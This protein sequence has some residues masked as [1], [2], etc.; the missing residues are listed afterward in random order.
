MKILILNYEYP[1]LGGGAGIVTKHLAEEFAKMNHAVVVVT[2]WFYGEPEYYTNNNITIVRLKSR[3]NNTY[4]S[5][6]L[7]MLSWIRYALN[8]FKNQPKSDLAFDIYARWCS[9]SLSEKKIQDTLCD[10]IAWT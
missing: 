3:R 10:I 6:P 1:P 5:N 7:E 9:C 8:Y 4:Q 2:T